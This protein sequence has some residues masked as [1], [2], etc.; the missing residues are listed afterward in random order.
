[1]AWFGKRGELEKGSAPFEPVSPMDNDN[2]LLVRVSGL[3]GDEFEIYKWLREFYSERWIAETLLLD[4][5]TAKQTMRRVYLKLGVKN[6]KALIQVYSRFE[7]PRK[8][9][10][11]T[12][13]IDKYADMTG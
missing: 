1:M 3:V 13:E 10:L 8:G 11:D 6:K 4:R 5:R 12:D 2:A 7:R 9:Q